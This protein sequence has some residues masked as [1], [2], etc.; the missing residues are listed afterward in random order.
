MTTS[1]TAPATNAARPHPTTARYRLTAETL[2]PASNNLPD[3]ISDTVHG[4]G[5]E[6]SGSKLLAKT[7]NDIVHQNAGSYPTF[8]KLLRASKTCLFFLELLILRKLGHDGTF[9]DRFR[10][11]SVGE[12]SDMPSTGGV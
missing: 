10:A 2:N 3:R 11:R 7:R 12:T 1:T 9:C 4:S 8:D 6:F 5:Q